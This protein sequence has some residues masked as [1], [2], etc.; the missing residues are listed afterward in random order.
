ME[1]IANDVDF[2]R[3][4]LLIHQTNRIASPALLVTN[5]DASKFPLI[6]QEKGQFDAI[7]CDVPCSGDGTMRKNPELWS[8]WNPG[9]GAGLHS[10]QVRSLDSYGMIR[11]KILNLFR[12]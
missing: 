10:L 5:H 8:K 1:Q 9:L 3:S 12:S 2:N 4:N 11:M 6:H 7:L